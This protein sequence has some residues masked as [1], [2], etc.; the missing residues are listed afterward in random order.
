VAKSRARIVVSGY[1]QGVG[2][3]YSAQYEGSRLGLAGWVRNLPTGQVEAE[4]EGE[5]RSVDAF[6]AW[7][8]RG[9]VSARVENVDATHS[10]F[11]GDLRDFAITR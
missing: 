6:V 9:P 10:T 8:H 2:F 3:R 5:A 1:V 7:C 11:V 4:V